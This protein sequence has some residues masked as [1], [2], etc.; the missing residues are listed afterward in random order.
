MN[1]IPIFIMPAKL[2]TPG[3]LEIN[4]S[5]TKFMMSYVFPMTSPTKFYHLTQIIS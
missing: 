1:M 4:D 3:L 2:A 5:E